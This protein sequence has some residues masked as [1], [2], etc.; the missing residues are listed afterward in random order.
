MSR[1]IGIR[2]SLQNVVDQDC[3]FSPAILRLYATVCLCYDGVGIKSRYVKVSLDRYEEPDDKNGLTPM[4]VL[5][6]CYLFPDSS[7][8]CQVKDDTCWRENLH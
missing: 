1:I 6:Q 7:L 3:T 4:N 5:S 2:I 8:L